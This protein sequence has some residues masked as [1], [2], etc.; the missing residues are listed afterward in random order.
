MN[1][2]SSRVVGKTLSAALLASGPLV[3][4]FGAAPARAQLLDQFLPT[5]V[6][7]S[8]VEPDVTV[9]SRHKSDYDAGGIRAGA[10]V[11]RPRLN[12]AFGYESNVLGRTQATGSALVNTNAGIEATSDNSRGNVNAALS[13]ADMRYL[14]LPNQ[15]FTNWSARAG[16][17][18]NIGRDSAS[19]QLSHENI[20]QTQRDLDVPQLSTPLAYEVDMLRVGYRALF[21]RLSLMPTLDAAHYSYNSGFAGSA[22]Y[23]QSYRNRVTVTPG[24]AAAYEF[25]TRRSVVVVVRNATAFYS[26]G[27]TANPKRDFND[28]LFLGGLD[29]DLNGYLRLRALIGYE[30]RSFSSVAYQIIQA[31]IA[32]LTLIYNPTAVTTVTGTFS[33]RIQDSADETTAGSTTLSGRLRVDYELRRNLI[34]SAVGTVARNDYVSGGSQLRYGGGLS[35]TYLLNRYAAVSASY[36]VNTRTSSNGNLLNLNGFAAGNNFIDHIVQLQLRFSL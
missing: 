3:P 16:G 25:A 1:L 5:D 26:H 35:S 15:S 27:S 8:G 33:R 9:T 21:N 11:I 10:Y 2:P 23:D 14:D 29:Y 19:V 28:T 36:D 22:I 17:T 18:Y 6:Y 32:E 7:G 13:V 30:R 12:E 31:P 34:L 4:F 20:F 24:V